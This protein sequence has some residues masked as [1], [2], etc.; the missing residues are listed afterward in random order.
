MKR[1]HCPKGD[2]RWLCSTFTFNM[3]WTHF[4]QNNSSTEHTILSFQ[5]HWGCMLYSRELTGESKFWLWD[6]GFYQFQSRKGFIKISFI[7]E[8]QLHIE[9]VVLWGAVYCSIVGIQIWHLQPRQVDREDYW[10][11]IFITWILLWSAW[12]CLFPHF[13]GT[14]EV[15]WVSGIIAL[16]AR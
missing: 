7:R 6:Y 16:S 4:H 5:I 14:C 13:V 11:V 2:K 9:S 15:P 1:F 8:E 12:R 3:L 10:H